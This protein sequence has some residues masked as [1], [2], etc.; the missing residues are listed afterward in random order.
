MA[1]KIKWGIL[2]CAAIAE[3]AFIPAIKK[4]MRAELVAI[5]SRAPSRARHWAEK[6]K[7]KKAYGYYEELLADPEVEAIYNPLPNHLHHHWTI[8]ALQAGKHVLCEK[9]LAL[10]ATQVKNIFTEAE[11]RNRLVMEGFMY[12]FHPQM[13][14]AVELI[15]SGVIGEPR[16]V[17]SAF[18]FIFDRDRS[19]YR[20]FAE[21]GGGALYDVGC[22][23]I[24]AA[25]LVFQSEP[26]EI[27]ATAHLKESSG[28]DLTT[29]LLCTFP[30]YRQS[31]LTCSFELEFQSSLEISGPLGRLFLTRAFSA[32]NFE[33]EIQLTREQKMQL[34]KFEPADQFQLMIEHFGQAIL[35]QAKPLIDFNDS[36]GNA[37]VIER[38]LK[39]IQQK[40]STSQI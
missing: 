2:G 19:N 38:A 36:Y 13:G 12:R 17:R 14:K 31:L 26:E 3:K 7:I 16:L 6:F 34:I 37:L 11:K 1:E 9:P 15:R 8:Q 20:W 4:S 35:G 25:R 10:T 39:L 24:N 32:K 18:T 5:A 28:V 22:Y 30:G 21:M 29:S 27:Q 33:T 40:K 23:P